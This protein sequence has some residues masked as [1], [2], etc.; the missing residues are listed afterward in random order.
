V[1]LTFSGP[2]AVRD[3]VFFNP[4]PDPPGIWFA[5]AIT[6]AATG[7]PSVSFSLSEDRSQ[8]SFATP[9]PSTWVLMGLGFTVL[10]VLVRRRA[11]RSPDPLP[12][13]RRRRA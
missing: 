11:A 2:G 7:D 3:W 12:C 10:S 13:S 8:L 4:Q 6:F 9:E 1:T 5:D